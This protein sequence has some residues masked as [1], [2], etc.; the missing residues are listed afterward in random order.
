MKVVFVCLTCQEI[1]KQ[2]LGTEGFEVRETELDS[3]TAAS[4]HLIDNAHRHYIVVEIRED[5]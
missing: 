3:F 4:E 1:N 2:H 5:K